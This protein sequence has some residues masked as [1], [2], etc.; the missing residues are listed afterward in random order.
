MFEKNK[1]TCFSEELLKEAVRRPSIIHFTGPSK[2]W[3]YD[4][5][6]PYKNEYY[7]YLSMK[8]WNSYKPQK[9]FKIIVKRVLKQIMP[10]LVIQFLIRL[11]SL[12]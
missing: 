12:P 9:T 3:Q 4:N 8:V 2:P 6:H 10:S 5:I 7:R 11:K 1:S